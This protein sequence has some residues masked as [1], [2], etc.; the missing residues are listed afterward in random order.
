M[1]LVRAIRSGGV[2]FCTAT[3]QEGRWRVP[4]G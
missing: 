4:W 1:N 3:G 2:K